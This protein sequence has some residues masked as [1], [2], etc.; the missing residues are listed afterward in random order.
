MGSIKHLSVYYG[1]EVFIEDKLQPERITLGIP[2]PSPFTEK[3]SFSVSLPADM[4]SYAVKLN[5]YNAFGQEVQTIADGEF[6]A[7]FYNFTWDGLSANGEKQASGV[8]IV[9]LKV[10][11][12]GLQREII[13]KVMVR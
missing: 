6:A 7:G 4:N 11:A 5:V 10:D 1:S 3:T 9:K 2:Y 12:A 8:Y 13:R